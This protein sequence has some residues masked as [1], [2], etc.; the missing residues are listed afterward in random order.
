MGTYLPN[1]A[2][3]HHG[4]PN[5]KELLLCVLCKCAGDRSIN[6]VIGYVLHE[7]GVLFIVRTG[8]FLLATMSMTTLVATTSLFVV[9]I[10]ILP[11]LSVRVCI[12]SSACHSSHNPCTF[13]VYGNDSQDLVTY[14][15]C[16]PLPPPSK[17]LKCGILLL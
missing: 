12:L 10:A 15:K 13:C 16:K 14:R 2:A 5:C 4:R 17:P 9:T 3:L 8:T 11:I 1:S 7:G 6:R